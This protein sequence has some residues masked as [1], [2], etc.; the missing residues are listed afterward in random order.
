MSV[1]F[2]AHWVASAEQPKQVSVIISTSRRDTSPNMLVDSET[3]ICGFEAG[4]LAGF[5]EGQI[6]SA[7]GKDAAYLRI[8]PAN[9]P[10]LVG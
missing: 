8:I 10:Q 1:N 4:V 3:D 9:A 7:G 6:T 2:S 5:G